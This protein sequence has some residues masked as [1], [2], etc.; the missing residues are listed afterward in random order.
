MANR[1]PAEE[2]NGKRTYL[3]T[4]EA[5]ERLGMTTRNFRL[6]RKRLGPIEGQTIVSGS[7]TFPSD[8]LDEWYRRYDGAASDDDLPTVEDGEAALLREAVNGAKQIMSALPQML[9]AAQQAIDAAVSAVKGT[10]PRT[11]IILKLNERLSQREESAQKLLL[12]TLELVRDLIIEQGKLEAERI[13]SDADQTIRIEK[14]RLAAKGIQQFAPIAK[15]G[16]ARF[17]GLPAVAREAQAETVLEVVRSLK[18]KPD[19][20]IQLQ[21]ILSAD[22]LGAVGSLLGFAEGHEKLAEALDIIRRDMTPERRDALM[23]VLDDRELTAIASLFEDAE[24]D[25]AGPSAPG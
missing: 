8:A 24:P 2:K 23:Q 9:G 3:T 5:C 18:E 13:K 20:L 14:T 21:A 22:Q 1:A 19:K 25:N 15:A 7:L 6:L 12:E 4:S 17:L 16:M 10:D 11:E